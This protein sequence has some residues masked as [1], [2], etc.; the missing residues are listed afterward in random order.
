[1]HIGISIGRV[2][3]HII[4]RIGVCM[5]ACVRAMCSSPLARSTH[6]LIDSKLHSS[7]ERRSG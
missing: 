7:F 2:Y 3:L 4:A 6:C 1:M 5:C